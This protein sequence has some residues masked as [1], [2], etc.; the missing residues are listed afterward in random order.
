[1]KKLNWQFV[2]FVTVIVMLTGLCV[3]L[4]G[5]DRDQHGLV[6]TGLGITSVVCVSWWFWVMF[7]IRTMLSATDRTTNKLNKIKIKIGEI[8]K[9]LQGMMASKKDK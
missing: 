9:L 6:L 3:S 7:V 2:M 5:I 8:R 1:M 4:L